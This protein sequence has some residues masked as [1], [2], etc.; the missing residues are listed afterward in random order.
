M[1]VSNRNLLFQGSI[2]RGYVSFREGTWKIGIILKGNIASSNHPF[3]S[4]DMLVSAE[5]LFQP[6]CFWCFFLL[7][8]SRVAPSKKGTNS[9]LKIGRNCYLF[10]PSFFTTHVRGEKAPVSHLQLTK[11]AYQVMRKND[12]ISDHLK[13][14]SSHKIVFVHACRGIVGR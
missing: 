12:W 14:A 7:Q 5:C 8:G 9:P 11:V 1:V 13:K 6:P 4:E 2:F 10:Q 3:F